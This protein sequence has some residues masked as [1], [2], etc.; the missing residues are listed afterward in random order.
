M[1][2]SKHVYTTSI[3]FQC[4]FQSER[5]W[6]ELLYDFQSQLGHPH[7]PI[8]V[9]GQFSQSPFLVL[10]SLLKTPTGCLTPLSY[11]MAYPPNRKYSRVLTLSHKAK[12]FICI[13]SCNL[14]NNP[15]RELC[16]SLT[17]Q[18]WSCVIYFEKDQV[19]E[20]YTYLMNRNYQEDLKSYQNNVMFL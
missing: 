19:N 9:F 10:T 6:H 12:Y 3:I 14:S 8:L 5:D 18:L 16:C 17:S 11:R 1:S 2:T 13:I 20:E 15:V 4:S 7:L